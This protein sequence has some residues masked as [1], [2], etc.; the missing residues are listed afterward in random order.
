MPARSS[1]VLISPD[2]NK[3]AGARPGWNGGLCAFMRRVLA[4]DEG[5][6]LYANAK[7]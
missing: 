5:G 3:R 1:S 2:A 7:A 6:A 4:T